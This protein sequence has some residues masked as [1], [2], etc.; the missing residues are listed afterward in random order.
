MENLELASATLSWV[1]LL[2]VLVPGTLF[3]AWVGIKLGKVIFDCINKGEGQ[4][5]R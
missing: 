5:W 4:D 1:F 3:A 2:I